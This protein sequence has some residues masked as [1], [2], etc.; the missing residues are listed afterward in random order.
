MQGPQYLYFLLSDDETM[1]ATFQNG[2]LEWTGNPMPLLYTPDGWQDLSIN[3]EMDSKYFGLN[4][5]YGTP[6]NFVE[7]GAGILK[8]VFCS[9]GYNAQ[10][11]LLILE[12]QLYISD[13]E[14][15]Y[16]YTQLSKCSLDLSQY[17]HA[18]EKV[19]VPMLEGDLKSLFAAN[20]SQQYEIDIAFPFAKPI[21]LDGLKLKQYANYLIQDPIGT[22]FQENGNNLIGLHVTST[23]AKTQLGTRDVTRQVIDNN[24]DIF[25]SGNYLEKFPIA[26][27]LTISV[28]FGLTARLA[29]GIPPNPAVKYFLTLRV[30]DTSGNIIVYPANDNL[31]YE[32]DGPTLLY[33]RRNQIK[34]TK[35]IAIPAGA[36]V[37][38]WSGINFENEGGAGGLSVFFHYDTTT[39]TGL[40]TDSN[41]VIQ[42]DYIYPTSFCLALEPLYVL[43]QLTLKMSDGKYTA[44]SD[45]LE[46]LS[47]IATT[48]YSQPY[49]LYTSGDAI[50]GLSPASLKISIDDFFGALNS[51][52]N[53][54]LGIIGNVLRVEPKAFWVTSLDAE[55]ALG[56]G[57]DAALAVWTDVLFNSINIGSENQTYDE[58]LGDINGRYEVNMTHYY[59]TP[60]RNINTEL[61]LTTKARRDM[62]GIE[63]TRINLDGKTTTD[64][65]A[66]NTPFEIS[67]RNDVVQIPGSIRDFDYHLLDRSINQ[68]T[69]GLLDADTSFNLKLT[70]KHCLYRHGNYLRSVLDKMDNQPITFT[71]ADK[72]TPMVTTYPNGKV[73]DERGNVEIGDLDRQI[74]RPYVFTLTTPSTEV[75]VQ[76]Q[77]VKKYSFTQLN[78][79]I[80]NKGFA[81]KIAVAPTDNRQQALNLLCSPEIDL[82]PTIDVWE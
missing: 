81:L 48:P 28:D 45:F 63:Y 22:S 18:G 46:S 73:V 50:R 70:P 34:A 41:V 62:Y 21:S 26:T 55:I 11:K 52:Y 68:Y 29:D 80:V 77:T 16:Y 5:T 6:Q 78:G 53:L 25:A 19:T 17:V 13:T 39:S 3:E 67:V 40:D 14:F 15:G 32:I 64:S 38:M 44:K 71:S 36:T 57:S 49:C 33:N 61:D 12:Q 43:Q 37:F 74:F 30:F 20:E 23:E 66:D 10:V 1:Y 75:N 31:L 8:T 56:E 4:L 35:T 59:G 9:L 54:G 82:T 42:Y 72:N 76:N 58:A 51:T 79:G 47:N 60:V 24:N 7:D 2:F 65:D 69:T 27:N